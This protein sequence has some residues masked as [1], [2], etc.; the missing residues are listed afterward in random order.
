MNVPIDAHMNVHMNVHQN[1]HM[2]IS[3]NIARLS[4]VPVPVN[5][6]LN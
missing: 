5:S 1:V 6:N 3:D 2:N 4:S